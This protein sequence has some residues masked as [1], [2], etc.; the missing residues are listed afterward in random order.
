MAFWNKRKNKKKKEEYVF[1]D[2]ELDIEAEFSKR[3][4]SKSEDS[5]F[6]AIERLQYVRTQC[7]QVAESSKYISELKSEYQAVTNYLSDVQIVEAK[8]NEKGSTLKT[9]ADEIINLKKNRK[10]MQSEGSILPASKMVIFEQHEND[11]PDALTNLMNDEK[12]CQ[13]VKH[14]M[15]VLEAEKISLK[16]DMDNY[17]MRRT[18]IRNI[19]IV[20]LLG[21]LGVFAIFI[22]SGQL[23][24]TSGMTLF[25]VVLLLVAVF[26]VL[27]FIMQRSTVYNFKLAEKKLARAITL[28]NKTKIKYVNVFSSVEYQLAKFKVKNSYELGKEYEA[29]LLEKKKAEKYKHSAVE[30]DD[31]T[32]RLE[33]ALKLLNLTDT[34]I[35]EN[36][37]EALSD[38]KEMLEVR[39]TLNIRRQKLREQIDYNMGRIEDAKSGIMNFVKKYPKMAEE[40]MGIVDSYDVDF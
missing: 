38:D 30:L 39:H 2:P 32:V 9:T 13:A 31:A 36:Q 33:K 23:K 22:I 6:L 35:W 25:M 17:G 11:F 21:I 34:S 37:I 40:V 4:S 5:Q 24:D 18:N 15:R 28:L 3:G 20:S 8:L 27:I 29:Y 14:D 26:V 1:L 12:Y 7:E 19:S 10:R 16:E